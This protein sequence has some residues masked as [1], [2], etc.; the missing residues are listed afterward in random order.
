[1]K[2]NIAAKAADLTH[3][4]AVTRTGNPEQVL[5]RSVMAC[6]L[7]EDQFYED[8]VAIADRDRKSTR[9]NSSHEFVSRMPSSA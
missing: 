8:G 1:M 7:W 5:R 9:L 4:G 6:L 2:T 3:G